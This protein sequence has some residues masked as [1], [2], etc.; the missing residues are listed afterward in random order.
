MGT[1][2]AALERVRPGREFALPATTTNQIRP[3]DV[4][5]FTFAA[6][7]SLQQIFRTP[8]AAGNNWPYPNMFISIKATADVH[9]AFGP[10]GAVTDP[11]N[12]GFVLQPGDSWQD[13][14]LN[15]DDA[16]FKCRGDTTGGDLYILFSSR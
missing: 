8:T 1:V 2:I 3:G 12:S 4:I 11:T 7:A 15:N 16:A 5:K 9:V 13:F 10:V 14:N 6:T